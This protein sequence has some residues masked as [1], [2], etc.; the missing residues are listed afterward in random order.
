M[1]PRVLVLVISLLVCVLASSCTGGN[2]AAPTPTA[3]PATS[4]PVPTDPPTSTPT[5][6]PT[7]TPTESPTSTPTETPEPSPTPIPG[8]FLHRPA[9]LLELFSSD[10]WY[11]SDPV[12]G[13][14]VGQLVFNNSRIVLSFSPDGLYEDKIMI[15]GIFE[16]DPDARFEDERFFRAFTS[17]LM[18]D[19][20][21]PSAIADFNKFLYLNTIT[22]APG[23]YE[24]TIEEF[25]FVLKVRDE[26]EDNEHIIGLEIYE[27]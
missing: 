7:S 18:R 8:V 9:Y 14:Q 2:E 4:T 10:E 17:T 12:L 6:S 5:E 23:F 13:I 24:T 16:G 15:K 21:P 22:P 25:K 20:I 19:F 27:K 11:W 26:K 3:V 1:K